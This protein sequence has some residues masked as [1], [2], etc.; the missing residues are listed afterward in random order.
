MPALLLVFLPIAAA[1]WVALL[2]VAPVSPTA[3]ATPIYLFGSFICH[4]LTDRS[5]HVDGVQLPVCARCVGIYAGGAVGALASF[6]GRPFT[7]RLAGGAGPPSDRTF[8]RVLL[9]AA[10][11][12][13]AITLVLEWAGLWQ[14]GNVTRAAAGLVLGAGVALLVMRAIHYERWQ[15]RRRFV[16]PPSTPI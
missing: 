13:T 8:D 16:P 6:V 10:A 12:P 4:Q 7:G 15:R 11:L 1:A 9:L 2:L 5:F 3:V 14:P